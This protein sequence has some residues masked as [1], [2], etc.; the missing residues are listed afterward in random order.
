MK[1]TTKD[2]PAIA[3]TPSQRPV[4]PTAQSAILA[5]QQEKAWRQW[6]VTISLILSDI[7]LACLVWG[8]T[9]YAI[10]STSERGPL[11]QVALISTVPVIAAW[12]GVRALLG[13]YPG[14]G[15]APAEELRRHV[16]SVLSAM[17]TTAIF[18]FGLSIGPLL[19]RRLIGLSFLA[20][21][22]LSPLV[23]HLAKRGMVKIGLWGKSVVI[24]GAGEAGKHLVRTLKGEW[25]LGYK[26]VAVFDF[27][28]AP[29]GGVLEG[30][31]YG[32]SVNDALDLARKRRIDTVIFAMP[33]VRRRH[34]AKFVDKASLYF[35]QVLVIPSVAGCI[36]SPVTTRDLAGPFGLE[37][38]HNLLDPWARRAKSTLDLLGVLVGGLLI[39]PLL[40]FIAVLIKLDSPGP[41][42]YQQKRLG[43]SGQYFC[44]W[45]FRTMHADAGRLLTKLLQK[46]PDLRTEWEQNHKLRD[47]PRI[48]RVGRILRKTS[49]DELPQLWNVLR[50]EMSLVGPR[51]IVDT[52]IVKY[53]EAY[54]LYRRVKPGMSGLWQVGGRSE[55]SYEER[56]EMDTYYVRN[57]SVWLDLVILAR[58][59]GAVLFS[60]GA[61]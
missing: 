10:E 36:T 58:T 56:V 23:R 32:G 41:V 30:V 54:E 43:S 28:V 35:R 1:F 18:A 6:L 46:R 33:N 17:A 53:K 27:F 31:E 55:T 12:V 9:A 50:E 61:A 48:T 22:F 8:A 7:L 47:D 45:K 42:F 24:L 14:Y 20:L 52:E 19:S 15:L 21:L 44:C 57:W 5:E 59:V 39:S 34:V 37:I 16:Y 11:S 60:R 2:L 25:G 51:P 29:R 4:E 3:T 40:I 38:K 26:P 49:L 13:L